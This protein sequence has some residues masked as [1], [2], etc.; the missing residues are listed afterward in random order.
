MK[1]K[2]YIAK[3]S[4]HLVIPNTL[5]NRPYGWIINDPNCTTI[6]FNDDEFRLID[7]N[8]MIW[9]EIDDAT[10][11]EVAVDEEEEIPYDKL[12]ISIEVTKRVM[13]E[14]K[15]EKVIA[16]MQRLLDAMYLAKE[17]KTLLALYI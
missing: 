10:G 4:R 13:S 7:D 2:P 6:E 3:Y 9:L 16:Q 1:R 14:L 15:D 11:L 8:T 12:D 17:K 5:E